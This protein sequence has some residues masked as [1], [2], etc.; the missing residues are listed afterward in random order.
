[1]QKVQRFADLSR[2]EIAG[3]V[4]GKDSKN[5]QL[6]TKTALTTFRAFC[7]EKHPDKT[8]DFHEISKEELNELLVD[9]YP[10]ARKKTGGHYKKSALS[11]IRF[12]LQRHFMLKR[13]FNI[14]SDPLFKQSNQV[15]EAVVVELKR[16][17][18]AKVEHHEPILTEDLAKIYSSYDPSSPDSKSLQYFVWFSIMF[19]LIRRGRENLRLHKRQSFSVSVDGAGRKYVYQHLDE[20]D[21][22]HRQNDDPFD[23]SGDGR[24][25]ENTEN[26]ASCPV[27]AFELYLSKLNPS[28]DSL[29]QRPKAFDNFN[30]SDSVWY[31]NAPLGKNTLGS[32]MKTISV[33]YK[34]SKVYTNHC[35]RSTAVSVLDNNN[36]EARHIMRVSSHKSETSI[37]SYSRQLTECKQ[38]EIS[39]TL[40]SACA[41]STTEIVPVSTEAGQSSST[42]LPSS[43]VLTHN[44]SASQET[45]HFHSG[46]FFLW[47]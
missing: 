33:E 34:L 26:P 31:C 22:N 6:V 1:M 11:S 2:E 25:Y 4:D 9:F 47:L 19:H 29:W 5:T 13:E 44:F 41:Q 35:I 42:N 28:L 45:V 7:E 37:R 46:A 20:L 43:P 27:K 39:H 21:K 15:F 40:T 38:R 3:L 23:S 36:F 18:F 12:G 32:L 30:E 24:M 8:Q 14:I 16:Q 17:G 10:N